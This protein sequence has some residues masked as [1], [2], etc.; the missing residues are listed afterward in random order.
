ML[1]A[2]YT[3]PDIRDSWARPIF[4][5]RGKGPKTSG[6]SHS[7]RSLSAKFRERQRARGKASSERGLDPNA[8]FAPG[9]LRTT[10]SEANVNAA[11]SISVEGN[12]IGRLGSV[13][14]EKFPKIAGSIVV[15]F[16]TYILSLLKHLKHNWALDRQIWILQY[17]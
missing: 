10:G 14:R 6:G 15:P 9:N 17:A 16:N 3:Y 2:A 11:R 1:R 13:R 5:V 4:W 7:T 12:S 8:G